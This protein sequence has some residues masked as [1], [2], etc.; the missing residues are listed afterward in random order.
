M[1][2][3]IF[4]NT[5]LCKDCNKKMEKAQLVKNG[6]IFRA[7]VCPN[8][9]EKIVH[10][11]DEQNYHKFTNLRNKEFSVKMRLVGNSYAVSIPKEIVSFMNTQ[12]RIMDDMVKLCFEEMGRLS[13]S[14][15]ENLNSARAR[16]V[17]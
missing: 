10:P 14:F 11:V 9:N 8:C 4:D 2:H 15:G 1:A 3:D 5:I 6:F 17:K 13:L 16:N 7:V 12:K